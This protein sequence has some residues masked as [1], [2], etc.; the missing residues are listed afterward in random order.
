[1]SRI[2]VIQVFRIGILT[3][4]SLL[5]SPFSA[6]RLANVS[7]VSEMQ[8]SALV[9]RSVHS[10]PRFS[11]LLLR[12]VLHPICLRTPHCPGSKKH[13]CL[14]Q[15]RNHR[16]V[17]APQGNYHNPGALS[18]LVMSQKQARSFFTAWAVRRC[19]GNSI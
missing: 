19:R 11:F 14:L 12:Q 5:G 15:I 7:S 10:Q 1:M 2:S 4:P 8:V 9:I 18:S 13:A 16:A 17:L 3:L 6:R